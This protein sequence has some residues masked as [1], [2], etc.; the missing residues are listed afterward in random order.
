MGEQGWHERE[1]IPHILVA[2]DEGRRALIVD[3]AVQ[4]VAPED[5]HRGSG[6]WAAMIPDVRPT[7]ALV[8]GLGAGTVVHLLS[9]RFDA[10]PIIAV[11]DDP[12]VVAIGR[13]EFGLE[14]P[15]LRIEIADAFSYVSATRERF[16]L[17]LVD[18]YHGNNPAHG[19]F[20][21][22]FLSNLRQISLPH[23]QVIFNCF[24]TF[25]TAKRL[26]RLQSTFR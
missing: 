24:S 25:L 13:A 11:D 2:E 14:L 16:D 10:V 17:I 26:V 22:P 6:Y 5:G 20:S 8:L 12:E 18:L 15:N 19:L 7:R 4:S 21:R 3:G 9:R 1:T 23:A